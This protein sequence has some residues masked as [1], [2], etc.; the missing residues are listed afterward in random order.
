VAVTP[1]EEGSWHHLGC[2]QT[3]DSPNE[4]AQTVS[5][6]KGEGRVR[7]YGMG[8]GKKAEGGKRI[9]HPGRGDGG[10]AKENGRRGGKR[11]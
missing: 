11:G 3:F 2:K 6:R 4:G 10:T 1:D 9:G 7:A 8:G 5:K